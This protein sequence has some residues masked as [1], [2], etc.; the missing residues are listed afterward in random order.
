M[1]QDERTAVAA[2]DAYWRRHFREFFGRSYS[3]PTVVGGYI[4]TRG[5]SCGSQPAQ[6]MNA[7]YC[8]SRDFLAWDQNL[9]SLGYRRV[10]DSWVYL[11]IAHEW[12]H[13]IQA[14]VSKR[15]VSV[16]DELQADCLA[17]AALSGARRDGLLRMEPGDDQE[18]ASSLAAL[19][20][21][22]PWTSRA[23]HGNAQQRIAAYNKG[24]RSGVRGC[25]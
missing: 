24:A 15:L 13:A 18:I 25:I 7:F 19:A 4:G 6:P 3:S 20:D 9:M 11:I 2:V 10:G 14:R 17:G 23:D 8:P 1:A 21:A 5:P 22:S 12:G 16:A